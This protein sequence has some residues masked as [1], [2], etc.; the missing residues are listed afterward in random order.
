MKLHLIN[1]F[2]F[3]LRYAQVW[4]S[5]GLKQR[6]NSDRTVKKGTIE[7]FGLKAIADALKGSDVGSARVALSQLVG[8]AVDICGRVEKVAKRDKKVGLV[9]QPDDV[10]GF[11]V[12]AD[13][14]TDAENLAKLSIRKGS[15][16]RVRGKLQTFGASAVCLS[17]CRL[18]QVATQKK[19]NGN[20]HKTSQFNGK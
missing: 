12:F 11:V 4:T 19:E 14:I 15:S 7:K 1:G 20:R 8:A 18:E 13:C 10:S 2:N 6:K 5:S 17:D 3:A 9:I 16:V